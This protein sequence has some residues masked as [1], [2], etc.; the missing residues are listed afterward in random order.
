MMSVSGHKFHGPKGTGFLYIDERVKLK[1]LIYGGG[2]QK[3]MRSGTD[4]VPGIAGLAAAAG[5]VYR[6]REETERHMTALKKKLTEGLLSMDNVWINGMSDRASWY[7]T[8][9]HAPHIVNASFIGVRSEVLLHTLEDRG[10]CVSAGS[11]CSSHKR[12]GSP[13]LT[14]IGCTK[15]E[16]E[17]SLRFS[18]AG[19]TTEQEIDWTLQTLLD[20]VPMLRRFTRK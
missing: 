18:F 4:N 12:A 3:G 10:I 9:L 6:D 13:T 19:T 7:D 1:P 17:S 2:Q 15:E 16:M 8:G 5:A 11:A 20:V 14:A